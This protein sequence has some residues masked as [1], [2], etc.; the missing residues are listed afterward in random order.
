MKFS[1]IGLDERILEILLENDFTKMTSIQEKCIPL[2]IQRD[3]ILGIAPTGTGKTFSYLLPSLH[4]V[5][6]AHIQHNN[7][8]ILIIVPTREL[9]KQV[10]DTIQLFSKGIELFSLGV[11]A[12]QRIGKQK[13]KLDKTLDII[14]ATPGRLLAFLNDESIILEN[15][16]IFVLDEVDRLLDMGFSVEIE[17]IITFIPHKNK[18]QTLLFGST[19]PP[20]VEKIAKQ[21]QAR[22]VKI[23][24]RSTFVKQKII[25]EIYEVEEEKKFDLLVTILK[26]PRIK[27]ALIFTRSQE[28]ARITTR[29]LLSLGLDVE[30]IHGGLTQRTRNRA[31][32]NFASGDVFVLV[33]TDIAARGIDIDD[34]SHVLNYNVPHNID[35]Y[36][37]R[38]G[39]TG[40]MFKHG[41]SCIL[42][43]PNELQYTEKIKQ[44]FNKQ[45]IIKQHLPKESSSKQKQKDRKMDRRFDP[46]KERKKHH[47]KKMKPPRRRRKR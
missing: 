9:V 23:D 8:S 37:H 19:L 1:D 31:M 43:S 7:P 42:A 26:Q 14:V 2:V 39:R 18:R 33:A 45:V 41:T 3:D 29:N 16:S 25:H 12:G 15:I 35:D 13:R 27:K 22:S 28:G 47:G 10:Q 5:I 17:E 11:Y 38:A 20:T 32:A 44:L 46:R 36:V 40:R 30:E 24:L 34:I 21:L 6:N 4:W